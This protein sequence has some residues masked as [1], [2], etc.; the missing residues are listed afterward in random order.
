MKKLRLYG[1]AVAIPFL[2]AIL[3]GLSP[4]P[5]RTDLQNLVF[6]NYQRLSPRIYDP[7]SPVRIIDIDDESLKRYGRQWPWPR[8]ELATI[9]DFLKEHGALAIGF[10]FLFAEPD[11]MGIGELI[12]G[13]PRERALALIA[14]ELD[15]N[16]TYD[17]AFAKS[18]AGAPVIL[19]AALVNGT[20][21]ARSGQAQG[22]DQAP[23]P[24]K[25]GFS[26][27]GDDPLLFL[28]G[29]QASIG[30]IK[31]LSDQAAGI[32]ALNWV[33]DRARVIRQVPFRLSQRDHAEPRGRGASSRA[34]RRRELFHQIFER[35]G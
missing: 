18:L 4:L 21:E 32:G 13:E 6:D 20:G 5:L 34:R 12:R 16:G 31:I 15:K 3:V 28:H 25:A 27:A 10:D 11:Q 35:L 7:A 23:L 30:P 14:R 19:G 22:E 2:L 29:F 17:E 1:L 33:P 24:V 9:V 8:T 26:H